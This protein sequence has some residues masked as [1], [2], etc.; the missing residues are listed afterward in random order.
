MAYDAAVDE[1]FARLDSTLAFRTEFRQ[2]KLIMQQFIPDGSTVIDIGAG[3][4]RYTEFLLHRN[5]C[6]GA[7]DLSGV[8]M[9]AL[10]NRINGSFGQRFLFAE[11]C[12]AS[13]TGFVPAACADAVLMMGPLYHLTL[14]RQQNEALKQAFRMLK[15]GGHLI[16]IFLNVMSDDVHQHSMVSSETITNVRFG[17]YWVEQYRCTPQRAYALLDQAGFIP[18]LTQSI[19]METKQGSLVQNPKLQKCEQFVMV[20]KKS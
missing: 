1:E 20:A 18:L 11:C 3:P 16:C 5:C 19:A 9:N 7:A 2:M 4:G 10:R 8:S 17:G 15:P 6:V 12:C 13:E 14:Q